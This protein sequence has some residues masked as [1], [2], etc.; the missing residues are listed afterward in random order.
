MGWGLTNFQD[1]CEFPPGR[2][3][4]ECVVIPIAIGQMTADA[5]NLSLEKRV[6]VFAFRML[7][8]G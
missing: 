6:M 2:Q 8:A 3:Q 7:N 4:A 5:S 1:D